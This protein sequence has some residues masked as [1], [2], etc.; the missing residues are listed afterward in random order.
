MP[1]Q[2]LESWDKIVEELSDHPNFGKSL[3]GN[4]TVRKQAKAIVDGIV[5][6]VKQNKSRQFTTS[7]ETQLSGMNTVV[8]LP[9]KT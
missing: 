8:Y 4:R 6:T 3:E 1:R 5:D 2:I 9:T 7:S